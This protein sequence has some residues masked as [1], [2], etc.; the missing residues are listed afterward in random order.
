MC[1]EEAEAYF[2]QLD[3]VLFINPLFVFKSHELVVNART[4]I[5]LGEQIV[6]SYLDEND[7]ERSRHSR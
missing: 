5:A 4:R 1:P 7:V 6:I 3:Y 2:E